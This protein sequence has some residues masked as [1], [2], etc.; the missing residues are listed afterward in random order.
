MVGQVIAV[1]LQS[2]VGTVLRPLNGGGGTEGEATRVCIGAEEEAS[3]LAH[4]EITTESGA[5]AQ[6]SQVEAGGI[7]ELDGS[8]RSLAMGLRHQHRRW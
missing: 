5:G 3:T 4:V 2:S 1:R 6:V 7:L 8:S